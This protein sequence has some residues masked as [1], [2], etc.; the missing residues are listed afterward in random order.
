[1][2]TEAVSPVTVAAQSKAAGDPRSGSDYIVLV[3]R[4]GDLLEC[5]RQELIALRTSIDSLAA[6]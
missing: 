2:A 3:A 1:M 5:I 6:P 4:V